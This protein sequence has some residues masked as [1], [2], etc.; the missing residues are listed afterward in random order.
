M[1]PLLFVVVVDGLLLCIQREAPNT[2][3]RMYAD[4]TAIVGQDMEVEMP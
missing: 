1:S 2:F 4:D 3:V